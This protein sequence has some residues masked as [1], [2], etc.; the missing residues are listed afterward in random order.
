[1][2]ARNSRKRHQLIRYKLRNV[3]DQREQGGN[4][5]GQPPPVVK[6]K[7]HESSFVKYDRNGIAETEFKIT[8]A[9][10]PGMRKINMNQQSFTAGRPPS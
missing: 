4:D 10:K 8:T 2:E 6:T 1:M 5:Y 7:T 9:A 3:L